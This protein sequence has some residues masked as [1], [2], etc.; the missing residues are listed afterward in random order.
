VTTRVAL[1]VAGVL[2]AVFGVYE[3]LGRGPANLVGTVLWLAGGVI[4]HDGVLA[5]ATIAVVWVGALLVPA[6]HRAPVAAAL[7]VLA[8]VTVSAVP[9][10]G[11]FG[12]RP[13]NPTLLDRNYLAGWLV[14]AGLV[15]AGTAGVVLL[16]RRR[17]RSDRPASRPP[18]C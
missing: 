12:A 2:F 15:S 6:R 17:S 13:D 18:R 14:F 10:L 5:F 9:V 8:T 11:R 3:L 16:R 4:L 7:I 1:G